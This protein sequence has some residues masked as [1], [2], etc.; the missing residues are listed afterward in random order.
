MK[1]TYETLFTI[2]ENSCDQMLNVLAK[3]S[4]SIEQDKINEEEILNSS[5][6]PNMFNFTKQ[7]QV[8][9]D[10]VLG[11]VY[12][13]SNNTKPSIVDDEKTLSDLIARVEM[14]KKYMSEIRPSELNNGEDVEIH[15]GWM[16]E[17]A[18]F[19][20]TDYAEKYVL[21]NAFFHL[22]TAY[23]ILRSKGVEIGKMDYLTNLEMKNK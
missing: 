3:A 20:G 18:Y 12:R 19:A 4:S 23:N 15:L 10:L 14:T 9:S 1:T 16:P 7:V 22:V 2:L 5:L 8:F 13:L 21:Q 6:A 17:G 11:S